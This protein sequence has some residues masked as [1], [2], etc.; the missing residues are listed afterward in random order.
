MSDTSPNLWLPHAVHAAV[1]AATLLAL[2]Q[3]GVT[4]EVM[5]AEGW[6]TTF[7][8]VNGGVLV[9]NVAAQVLGQQPDEAARIV[10]EGRKQDL[11]DSHRTVV[12]LL[13][14]LEA[15]RSK[16]SAED[17]EAERSKLLA[18]G[19][20][21]LRELEGDVAENDGPRTAVA[22]SLLGQLQALRK[23]D[24]EGFARAIDQLGLK[25]ADTISGEWRGAGWT[26]ALF[27]VCALLVW[28]ASDGSHTRRAGEGMTGGDG[29][30]E[31]AAAPAGRP[32]GGPMAAAGPEG[33]APESPAV[34]QLKTELEKH[35]EDITIANKL[36]AAAIAAEDMAN[37]LKANQAA[38]KINPND[39]EARTYNAV[40]K[41]FIGRKEE[42]LKQLDEITTAFPER[43]PAYIYKGLLTLEADPAVALKAF[44]TA[45]KLDDNP[46]I[47]QMIEVAKRKVS[48]QPGP[49]P[50]DGPPGGPGGPAAGPPPGGAAGG[51][52]VLAAGKITLADAG[53][54]A[55]KPYLF[56][57][58]K[59]PGGGPPFAAL[60]LEVTTFPL[61]F[62]I[63]RANLIPMMAG[64]PLPPQLMLQAR[65]DAD[66]SATTKDDPEVSA[67]IEA[68]DVGKS[69][70][71]LDLK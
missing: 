40:L 30:G 51:D 28:G 10:S 5:Q 42:A 56:V 59:S 31:P 18:V 69:G 64:R 43:A 68:F 14:N 1:A 9:G 29:A 2:A 23:A 58:L 60:K 71:V 34:T 7:L 20:S 25:P 13:R 27:G 67:A 21:A 50:F 41:A 47:L 53:K 3:V 70:A 4:V 44:E 6:W 26:V 22:D 55:G 39:P 33:E 19:A 66:G 46:E 8:V 38:L 15:E 36:T 49:S 57:F 16:L 52:E 37:A 65:L 61:D 48:G 45:S 62:A 12:E 17:Y 35:P 24:P 63:T 54:A 32:A 11:T